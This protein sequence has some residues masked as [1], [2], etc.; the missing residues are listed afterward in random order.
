MI[1]KWFRPASFGPQML[2]L[3]QKRSA[4]GATVSATSRVVSCADCTLRKLQ[5]HRT[6]PSAIRF[7]ARAAFQIGI[8]RPFSYTEFQS[9]PHSLPK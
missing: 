4:S 2:A 6:Q 7:A 3:P 1:P 5:E 9:I 8:S